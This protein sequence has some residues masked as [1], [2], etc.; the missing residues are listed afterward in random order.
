VSY[1]Q[2]RGGTIPFDGTMEEIMR[3]HL[4]G[5]PNLEMLPPAERPVVAR[6]LAKQPLE[7]WPCCRD[8][9]EALAETVHS[10]LPR[11]SSIIKKPPIQRPSVTAR[12]AAKIPVPPLPPPPVFHLKP[13]TPQPMKWTAAVAALL[14]LGGVLV[15]GFFFFFVF[16]EVRSELEPPPARRQARPSPPP[17]TPTAPAKKEEPVDYVELKFNEGVRAL[18]RQAYQEAVTAFTA[19]IRL[20]PRDARLFI[21]RAKANL[22]LERFDDAVSDCTEAIKIRPNSHL[23]YNE[24]GNAYLGLD[25][26]DQALTDYDKAIELNSRDPIYFENRARV[27][28]RMGNEERASADRRRANELRGKR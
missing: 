8:F 21:Y 6:A 2:L 18:N 1:C 24:R 25:D 20:Q 14:L 17:A 16:R 10:A 13:E 7:R 4:T 12:S 11:P 9:V 5:V 23:A 15:G 26:I 27:Y 19:A 22:G 3:G 28:E